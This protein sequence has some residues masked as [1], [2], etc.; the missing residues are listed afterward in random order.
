MEKRMARVNEGEPEE[1]KKKRLKK[2]A[3]NKEVEEF[4]HSR[5]TYLVA[6]FNDWLP[7]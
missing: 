2:E 4:V 6:S 3:D 7:Y 5:R 1:A